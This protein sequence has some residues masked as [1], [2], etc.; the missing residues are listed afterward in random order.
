MASCGGGSSTSTTTTSTTGTTA[1]ATT[2]AGGNTLW[3]PPLLTGTVS[4]GVTSYELVLAAS[5]V[6]FQT[7][8]KTVTYGDNGNDFWGP[9][10]V[11]K[12]GSKARMQ[13]KNTLTQDTTTH[14]HGMLVPGPVDGGP[15]QVVAAGT[16]WLTDAFTVKNN[17][18]TYWYH[19][20]MVN[21]KDA[22]LMGQ[23]V[24]Q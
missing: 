22:G 12:K 9:T 7:G 8:A 13:V 4:D 17:A 19:C 11:M 1:V 6:Q 16:T 15:H 3:I 21:H 18:A 23:F 2:S 10:L 5:S 14:W 24:V 20:H